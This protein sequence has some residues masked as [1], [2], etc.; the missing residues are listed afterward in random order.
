MKR[1]LVSLALA[2]LLCANGALANAQTNTRPPGATAPD[3]RLNDATR[4][5]SAG[6]LDRALQLG[7][8]YL[9]QHPSDP[10]ARV[11]A[12]RIHMARGDYDAAY[13]DL[14]AALK[15]DPRNVDALY[16]LGLVAGTLAQQT[17]HELE[18]RAPDSA[19]LHQLMAELLEAQDKRAAAEKEYEAALA[20]RP[21]LLEALL[22][23]A[24]LKRIRLECEEAISLYQKAET[25][26]PTFD[27]A[28]GLGMCQS[29]LQEDELAVAR[30]EQAIARN[31]GAA[32]AWV[33]LGTSLNKL[34]RRT[35]AIAKLQ[36]AIAI[37]PT[38]GEAYYALGLTL[39][40]AG[41]L[42]QAQEA[43]RKAEQYGGAVGSS[44][45]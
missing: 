8:A 44:P 20:R 23:L 37:E 3:T 38:M 28:Y 2:G 40:A 32:V 34:D 42:Q 12:A 29:L 30:F 27:G 35:E 6:E 19:R 7:T 13:D 10:R 31:P 15:A 22:G 26:R 9:K 24:K 18:T 5:L 43:F 41:Q 39:Q 36:H 4:A 11:L 25:I 14:Q 33:G 17:F 21:D 45:R 16:Y 1:S